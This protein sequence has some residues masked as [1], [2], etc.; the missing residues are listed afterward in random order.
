MIVYAIDL[1]DPNVN[2][3]AKFAKIADLMNIFLPL[4]MIG[5]AF[6]LL[7]MLLYGGYLRITAGDNPENVTKAQRTMTYAILGL[8]IIIIS[9]A[10]VRLIT[11]IFN[12][13]SPI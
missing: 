2:P 3:L 8:V 9:F 12:I 5:A 10:V 7:V 11:A 1:S 13:A 4:L 6:V